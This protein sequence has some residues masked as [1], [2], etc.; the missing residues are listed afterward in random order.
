MLNY[1]AILYKGLN[2]KTIKQSNCKPGNILRCRENK[3]AM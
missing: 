1:T 3:I 2:L